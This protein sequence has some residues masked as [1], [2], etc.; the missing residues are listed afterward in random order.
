V[1]DETTV[2]PLGSQDVETEHAVST[3]IY[4]SLMSVP[5]VEERLIN[6]E[7]KLEDMKVSMAMDAESTQVRLSALTD[8]INTIGAIID[9]VGQH[10]GGFMATVEK[11]GIGAILGSV[12]GKKKNNGG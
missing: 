12:M 3:P 10:V 2:L 6:L 8:A 5:R 7:N 1:S 11:D 4:D 9:Q